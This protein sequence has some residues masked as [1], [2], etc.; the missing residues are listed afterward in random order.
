MSEAAVR[1]RGR[2][3]VTRMPASYPAH[4]ELG[5]VLVEGVVR[6][7]AIVMLLRGCSST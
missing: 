5:T 7:D 2:I 4:V 3:C 6:L 1:E